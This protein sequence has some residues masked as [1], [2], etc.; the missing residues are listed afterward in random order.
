MSIGAAIGFAVGGV[1][2]KLS[3]SFSQPI[4]SLL[5]YIFF[6]G[7]ATLQTLAIGKADLGNTCIAILGLEA[8]ATLVVSFLVFKEQQS[9]LQLIGFGLIIAGVVILRGNE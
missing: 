2:M 5:V 7:G 9:L 3:A 4:Y 6:A 8:V 1:F